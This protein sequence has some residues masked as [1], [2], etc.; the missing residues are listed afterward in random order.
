MLLIFNKKMTHSTI[1]K[2]FSFY[3]WTT[4]IIT[5][6]TAFLIYLLLRG[7]YFIEIYFSDVN[8]YNQNF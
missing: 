1:E 8:N 5:Q 3:F 4:C 6:N 7:K 2:V